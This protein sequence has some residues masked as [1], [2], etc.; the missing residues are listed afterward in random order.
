MSS[1]DEESKQPKLVSDNRAQ[2]VRILQ[3]QNNKIVLNKSMVPKM[4]SAK[5]TAWM[6]IRE[7]SIKY[8]G[9][10]VTID[11]LK[12]LL[13]NMKSTVKKNTDLSST[14]NKPIK[15][16]QW[17]KDFREILNAEENSKIPGAITVGLDSS[18][19]CVLLPTQLNVSEATTDTR[20]GSQQ[21]HILR[22]EHAA[23]ISS[24]SSGHN[25]K[26]QR[27]LAAETEETVG[28]STPE[29]QRLVLLEQLKLTRLQI[30]K[31]KLQ[32]KTY[33]GKKTKLLIPKRMTIL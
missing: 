14:G 25:S 13:N 19:K 21:R 28:L 4:V 32:L 30:E 9:K 23:D 15:L 1:S 27:L 12:K 18:N 5:E 20:K 24:V 7:E 2:L 22:K 6:I 10:N 29:L 17:E 11:Q 3:L 31:E 8:T 26:K 33:V 16:L